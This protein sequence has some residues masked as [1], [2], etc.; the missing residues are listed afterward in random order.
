MRFLYSRV[1]ENYRYALHNDVLV[2]D[3]PHI[4]RCSHKTVI[5]YY[6]CLQ[7]SVKYHVVQVCSLAAIGYTI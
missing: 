2:D 6:N 3:G 7:Y 5:L 1:D 4:R